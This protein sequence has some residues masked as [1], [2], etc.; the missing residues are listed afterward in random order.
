MRRR[1]AERAFEDYVREMA[2]R[3]AA[4][5]DHDGPGAG[6]AIPKA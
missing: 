2:R 6:D 5:A 3:W 1:L 4:T